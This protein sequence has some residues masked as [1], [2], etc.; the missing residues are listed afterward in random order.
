M[1]ACPGRVSSG[2]IRAS[3]LETAF[4]PVVIVASSPKALATSAFSSLW[5]RMRR[6]RPC[7]PFSAI[8]SM[9]AQMLSV[10]QPL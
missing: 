7:C 5:L 10:D 9:A 1:Q 3:L 6:V 2:N 4:P 8:P